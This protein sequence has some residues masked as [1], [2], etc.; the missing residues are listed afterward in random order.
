VIVGVNRFEENDAQKVELQK[1]DPEGERR[2]I[3]RTAK[4][5]AERNAAAAAAA[6]TAVRAA[7]QGQENLLPALREALRAY[8]TVGELCEVLRAEWGMYDAVRTRA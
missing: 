1:I 3:E 7:A 2:Q 5:R 4:V 6:V 8:C